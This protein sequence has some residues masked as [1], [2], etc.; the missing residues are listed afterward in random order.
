MNT[1]GLSHCDPNQ[2]SRQ[3]VMG[4]FH[5]WHTRVVQDYTDR[6]LPA[7]CNPAPRRRPGRGNV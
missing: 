7:P 5:E 2:V 6:G 3:T 4:L 1:G